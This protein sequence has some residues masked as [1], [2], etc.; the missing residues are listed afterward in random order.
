MRVYRNSRIIILHAT[1][2]RYQY[3]NLIDITHNLYFI[4]IYIP[5]LNNLYLKKEK[6]SVI[7]FIIVGN[8]RI[9]NNMPI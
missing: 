3:P 7:F 5:P 6:N 8:L 1:H 2:S 9:T 4:N